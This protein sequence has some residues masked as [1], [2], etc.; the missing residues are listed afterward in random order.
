MKRLYVVPHARR[1]GLGERL[2]DALVH[3]A[4]RIGYREMRLDT[5]SSMT[6]AIALYRNCGFEPIAPYYDTPV[7][8]TIFLRRTLGRNAR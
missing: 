6:G 5:L 7:A 8:G 2:V 3:G 4:E 1:S